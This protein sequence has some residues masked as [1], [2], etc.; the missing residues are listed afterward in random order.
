[1]QIQVRYFAILR[2]RLGKEAETF[3]LAEGIDVQQAVQHI[4]ERHPEISSLSGRF[5]TAVNREMVPGDV[6]LRDGDELALIPP[7]AGGRDRLA[8]MVRDRA[9]SLDAVMDAVRSFDAG[10]IVT[11]LGM[12]RRHNAG[13]VVDRL[14]YEAYDEMAGSELRRICE[15]VESEHAGCRV[16]VEHRVGRLGVGDVAVA[17][18]VSAPHRAEAFAAC[19]ATIEYLKVRVP[20]WKKEFGRDGAEWIG[21]GE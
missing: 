13:R 1:M 17:I 4:S 15:L 10:A 9:P 20:I 19:R 14:E 12:V 6:E 2:E 5:Q 7:V 18:A 8:R 3:E 16:A 21:A 11:F